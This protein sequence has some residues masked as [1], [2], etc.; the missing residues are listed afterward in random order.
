MIVSALSLLSAA[1]GL[2]AAYYWLMASQVEPAPPEIAG[3]IGDAMFQNTVW[4]SALIAASKQ[5]ATLN[6]TAALL[7]AF[8]VATGVAASLVL[9]WP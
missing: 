7:T 3:K 1:I 5:S 9:N 6:K 2:A 4:V 8:S